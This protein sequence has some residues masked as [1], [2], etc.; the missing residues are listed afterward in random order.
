MESQW[1]FKVRKVRRKVIVT[2]FIGYYGQK[3]GE[4]HSFVVMPVDPN[5]AACRRRK[6]GD[7]EDGWC[8]VP[9]MK[10]VEGEKIFHLTVDD[11]VVKCKHCGHLFYRTGDEVLYCGEACYRAGY[12]ARHPRP[13]VKH[14]K[15]RCA[16]CGH[17]FMPARSTAK[18]CSAKCRVAANRAKAVKSKSVKKRRVRANK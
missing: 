6:D 2:D 7:L 1:R 3:T 18:F 11:Q 9:L 17:W 8:L 12:R 10:Q 4:D 14:K 5:V 13:K 16:H 15:I